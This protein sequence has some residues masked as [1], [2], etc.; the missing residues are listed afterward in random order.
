MSAAPE[1]VDLPPS[2]RVFARELTPGLHDAAPGGRVRL[3]AL[4]RW[5]QDVAHADVTDAGLQDRALWVVRKARL[6]VRRFP[7][8]GERATVQTWG[9]GLG[10]LWAERRTRVST[11]AGGHVEAAAIWVHLDP[12][13]AMPARLDE[14]ELGVY[15]PSAQGR[16]VKA[17]LRH[18]P[19]P[20]G[21]P[22]RP[23]TFRA[24]ELDLAD[25]INNAA[26]WTPL[27]EELLAG[28]EPAR[29]DVELEYRTPGQPGEHIV[30]RDGS[31]R[32]IVA[33]DG[34]V[35]ASFVFLG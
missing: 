34:T 9:S 33:A 13:T 4:A 30:V 18:P 35:L 7:R 29:V 26:Y 3:D 27:E 5:L 10:S 16:R 19:P 21:A 2:G 8:F 32:W 17:S 14:E 1:L 12:V 6:C 25:H 11:E 23:W 28:E 24:T 15:G 22:V 20:E 31:R